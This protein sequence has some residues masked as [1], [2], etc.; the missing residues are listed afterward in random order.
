MCKSNKQ[1][2]YYRLQE[3]PFEGRIMNVPV[4]NQNGVGWG[5][6]DDHFEFSDDADVRVQIYEYKDDP[7][8]EYSHPQRHG[9]DL[10]L[11]HNLGVLPERVKVYLTEGGK[12]FEATSSIFS[13]KPYKMEHF[14]FSYDSKS[15]KI[16]VP[17]SDIVIGQGWGNLDGDNFHV[18]RVGPWPWYYTTRSIFVAVWIKDSKHPQDTAHMDIHVTDANEAPTATIYQGNIREGTTKGFRACGD[19]CPDLTYRNPRGRLQPY[20][21]NENWGNSIVTAYDEEGDGISYSVL[22]SSD[23]L[24]PPDGSNATFIVL[25]DVIHDSNAFAASLGLDI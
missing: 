13:L 18:T 20:Y 25:Q 6:P 9:G 14:S 16:K 23:P 10:N 17:N 22:S 21:G 2:N 11:N 19:E 12:Y 15:V 1:C 3:Q 24:A 4:G 8:Y 7:D 5:G